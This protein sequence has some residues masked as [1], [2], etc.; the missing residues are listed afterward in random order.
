MCVCVRE[1]ERERER[2]KR[3]RYVLLCFTLSNVLWSFITAPMLL[4]ID[5]TQPL[6]NNLINLEVL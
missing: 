6:H 1:R 2:E 4:I 3:E 5:Y